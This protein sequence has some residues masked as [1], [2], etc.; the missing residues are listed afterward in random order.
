MRSLRKLIMIIEFVGP[1]A[2]GKSTI[3]QNLKENQKLDLNYQ[4]DINLSTFKILTSFVNL[5]IIT[6]IYLKIFFTTRLTFSNK[7]FYS[8]HI[9]KKIIYFKKFDDIEKPFVPDEGLINIYLS[10]L[11]IHNIS[12]YRIIK[13][14]INTKNYFCIILKVDPKTLN[15]RI[16]R[17][18]PPKGW[19][20]RN[21][22]A[23]VANK[24]NIY[25][26]I[27]EQFLI[28]SDVFFQHE[29]I[30]YYLLENNSNIENATIKAE[31]II[32]LILK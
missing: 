9:T 15:E 22:F 16:L 6:E 12:I 18:G 20:G 25:Y 24:E 23:K 14:Y 26:K 10:V 28:F 2:S 5:K 32:N 31:E 4:S 1:S 13:E 8:R 11:S 3:I 30:K 27:Q 21:L 7:R 19:D 29:K 17:R